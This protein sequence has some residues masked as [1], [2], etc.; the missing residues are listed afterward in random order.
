MSGRRV[1]RTKHTDLHRFMPKEMFEQGLTAIFYGLRRC[2]KNVMLRHMMSEM[3]ER[4]DDIEI[5]IWSA[6]AIFNWHKQWTHMPKPA[7]HTNIDRMKDDMQEVLAERQAWYERHFY[8][9][10]H[11]DPNNRGQNANAGASERSGQ[12]NPKMSGRFGKGSKAGRAIQLDG[13]N[14]EEQQQSEDECEECDEEDD[15][16]NPPF[17]PLWIILDDVVHDNTIRHCEPLNFCFIA[18]RHMNINIIVFS[19]NVCGSGSVPP[20]IREQA[21][22]LFIVQQPRSMKA[23]KLLEEEYLTVSDNIP[24]MAGR[25][26][27]SDVLLMPHRAFVITKTDG[28]ARSLKDY[29]FTYGPVPF[30]PDKGPVYDGKPTGMHPRKIHNRKYG[31][32]E[33][34]EAHEKMGEESATAHNPGLVVWRPDKKRKRASGRD[35]NDERTATVRSASS[36]AAACGKRIKLSGNIFGSIGVKKPKI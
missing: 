34:W 27:M 11:G 12:L 24:K 3:E 15:L 22:V 23:R 32:D 10:S 21:E 36:V 25:N 13:N 5:Q 18:G 7:F 33:Q 26:L 4:T 8:N 35:R 31:T 19:Q 20:P 2:G 29:C 28:T 1:D 30:D 6:T 17:P 9:N 14:L 16:A